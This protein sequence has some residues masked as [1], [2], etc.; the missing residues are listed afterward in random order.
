MRTE[1]HTGM[2]K[3]FTIPET[4]CAVYAGGTLRE[5]YHTSGTVLL[6]LNGAKP[7]VQAHRFPLASEL[8]S[9]YTDPILVIDW[10]DYGIPALPKAFWIDLIGVL[11]AQNMPV[12]I[13]CAGGHGRTGT[14]LAILASL[15]GIHTGDPVKWVR[16]N[17]CIAAVESEGQM[18]YI[19]RITGRRTKERARKMA[20][21]PDWIGKMI[22]W[23]K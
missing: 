4:T 8:T 18:R 3:V 16:E 22:G 2:L 7:I 6:S 11:K 14:A 20:V 21:D 1:C 17:Y 10:P 23:S 5:G 12:S 15:M 9:T 19:E 13:M